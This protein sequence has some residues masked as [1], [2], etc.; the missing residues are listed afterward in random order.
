MKRKHRTVVAAGI[1]VLLLGCVVMAFSLYTGNRSQS[2]PEG[3][4]WGMLLIDIAD[5]ESADQYHVSQT[6]V[7][8]LAVEEQ[9]QAYQEGVRAGDRVISVN[10]KLIQSASELSELPAGMVALEI[11]RTAGD[12]FTLSLLMDVV[13]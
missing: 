7:Y 11:E 6:G 1:C 13:Q 5:Q 12:R 3:G 8:V 4:A 10:Q 2:P 9:S